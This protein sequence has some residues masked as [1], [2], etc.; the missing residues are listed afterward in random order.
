MALI[1]KMVT[2][3]ARRVGANRRQSPWLNEEAKEVAW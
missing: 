1:S 3:D 2:A